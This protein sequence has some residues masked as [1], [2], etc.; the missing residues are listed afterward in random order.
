MIGR[1]SGAT[2]VADRRR[3]RHSRSVDT[4][5]SATEDMANR[6]GEIAADLAERAAEVAGRAVES[7]RDAQRAAAPVVKS[8]ISSA[9]GTL[10]E[11]AEKAAEVLADS[12]E[13][14]AQD[15]TEH[16]NSATDAARERLADAAE[17]FAESV[18]PKRRRR[19]RRMLLVGMLIGGGLAAGKMIRSKLGRH[20]EPTEQD[21]T[22]ASIP[23]PSVTTAPADAAEG[24]GG[25]GARAQPKS[26]DGT[27]VL[28]A[29]QQ[30]GAADTDT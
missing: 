14:L 22:P 20:D 26:S 15:G 30:G 2:S 8:A 25:D 13:R 16:V 7:A 3:V 4:A 6:A 18:R 10:S 1:K 19:L 27:G 9:A 12:A 21:Y 24:A 29:T 23:I 17:A 11:A 28:A 5:T